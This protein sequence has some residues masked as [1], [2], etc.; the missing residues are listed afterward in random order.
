M[1]FMRRFLLIYEHIFLRTYV[2]L[3]YYF[4]LVDKVVYF[5][6]QYQNVSAGL[7]FYFSFSVHN[8]H[9]ILTT[10]LRKILFTSSHN[11]NIQRIDMECDRFSGMVGSQIKQTDV[12]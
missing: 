7:I 8:Q 4:E 12:S 9:N 6:S 2:N 1:G 5:C 10:C 11:Y 3:L